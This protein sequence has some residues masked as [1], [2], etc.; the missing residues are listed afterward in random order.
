MEIYTARGQGAKLYSGRI[1]ATT[2]FAGVC[3]WVTTPAGTFNAGAYHRKTDYQIDN[4][5][6]CSLSGHAVH[7]FHAEGIG[8][9]AEAGASAGF[10][11]EP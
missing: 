4:H 1:Q 9:V 10:W 5:G 8:K 2:V 7:V 6:S 11:R 3:Y